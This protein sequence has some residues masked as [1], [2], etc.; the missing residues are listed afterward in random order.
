VREANAAVE[1]ARADLQLET[2]QARAAL[3]KAPLPPSATPLADKTGWQAWELDLARVGFRGFVVALGG[4]I[5]LAA[6]AHRSRQEPVQPKP[7]PLELT[8]NVVAIAPKRTELNSPKAKGV[9]L[10]VTIGDVDAFML[11]CVR[12]DASSRLS[13][14]EAFVRYRG[15]CEE[16]KATPVDVSAFG[17]RLDLLRAELGLETRTKGKE[18]F[19][20][21][22]KLA[23]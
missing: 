22:L 12:K 15:W 19:F 6:G 2:R 23:S 4:A 17:A 3:D 14:V 10:P 1:A 21:G 16:H 5:L 11:D 13:W 9:T 18:V 20:V 8:G 7:L